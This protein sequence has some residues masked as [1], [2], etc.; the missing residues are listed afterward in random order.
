M[1][2]KKSVIKIEN[3]NDN[4]CLFRAIVVGTAYANIDKDKNFY[5]RIIRKKSKLQTKEARKLARK[6]KIRDRPCGIDDI[7]KIEKVLTKFRFIVFGNEENLFKII[8]K[9]IADVED[10][11]ITN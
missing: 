9:T 7:K 11:D 4:L 8:Y 2:K 3:E 10:T 1:I 5:Q 6:F